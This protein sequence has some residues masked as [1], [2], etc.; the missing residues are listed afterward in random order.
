LIVITFVF[1]SICSEETKICAIYPYSIIAVRSVRS[2]G[3]KVISTRKSF[4]PLFIESSGLLVTTH[5]NC[6]FWGW[7]PQPSQQD[8]SRTQVCMQR[9][10]RVFARTMVGCV[11]ARNTQRAC[12]P[13][14][15]SAPPVRRRL[16]LGTRVVETPAHQHAAT[17]ANS[18]YEA[19][20]CVTGGGWGPREARS[21][22]NFPSP[23]PRHRPRHRTRTTYQLPQRCCSNRW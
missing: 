19:M 1:L 7:E 16:R 10:S 9:W 22:L 15:A 17:R 3:R 2:L 4:F 5:K 8:T 6:C 21:A 14:C 18:A 20:L 13:S 12:V 11:H 23:S